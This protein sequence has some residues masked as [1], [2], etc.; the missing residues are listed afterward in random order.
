MKL[1]SINY[2]THNADRYTPRNGSKNS[3]RKMQHKNFKLYHYLQLER[4]KANNSMQRQQNDAKPSSNWNRYGRSLYP[5]QRQQKLHVK[6]DTKT[7]DHINTFNANTAMQITECNC[8]IKT[9][10]NSFN[11]I[12]KDHID[13]P[14]ANTAKAKLKLFKHLTQNLHFFKFAHATRT[15]SVV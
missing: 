7:S 9:V 5:L 12:G 14:S 8:R 15:Q 2:K 6:Y 10:R 13:I 11:V 3:T 1:S 4:S